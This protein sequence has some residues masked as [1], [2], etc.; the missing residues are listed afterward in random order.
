MLT[1]FQNLWLCSQN[2]SFLFGLFCEILNLFS[3][4]Q[5][6]TEKFFF[7]QNVCPT[8][9]FIH[10]F[11][12]WINLF[13]HLFSATTSYWVMGVRGKLPLQSISEGRGSPKNLAAHRRVTKQSSCSL[14]D[15]LEFPISLTC[16]LTALYGRQLKNPHRKVEPMTPNMLPTFNFC[17]CN[18]ENLEKWGIN[19]V[20]C[21]Q[22]FQKCCS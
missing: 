22:H 13:I 6:E 15:I 8:H 20:R 12:K 3:K 7:S 11:I 21:Q 19:M 18:V 16:I 1:L 17:N 10:L 9:W 14:T 5:L 4:F 2:V